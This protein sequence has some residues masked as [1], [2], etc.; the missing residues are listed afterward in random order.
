[1]IEFVRRRV[2]RQ[3][4]I[5]DA[6]RGLRVLDIGCVGANGLMELHRR[7]R[8]VAA[9]CVGLDAASSP[10]VIVGDAQNFDFSDPFDLIVAGEIVE[11]LPNV[12]G[13]AESVLRNLKPAGRL[14]LTTPNPYS[15]LALAKAA[16]GRPVPNDACHIALYDATT[17]MNWWN[18][19]FR[20]CVSGQVMYY[21]ETGEL[22]WPYRLNRAVSAWVPGYSIGLLLDLTVQGPVRENR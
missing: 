8:R 2:I 13:F 7:I 6:A 19:L 16:G 22:S 11:H 15:W 12:R 18:G 4:Y 5:T 20:D 1:V 9:D 17:L 10:G 21:E 3:D 14:I